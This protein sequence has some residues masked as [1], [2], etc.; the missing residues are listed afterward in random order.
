[1]VTIVTEAPGSPGARG[2]RA[3]PATRARIVAAG[4]AGTAAAT[5]VAAMALPNHGS[6]AAAPTGRAI[7]AEQ[8]GADDRS[9]VVPAPASDAA[10]PSPS[11][12]AA[13]D[14][15]TGGS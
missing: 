2:R 1:M 4:L 6:V 14:T 5:M 11:P 7:L 12:A 9:M 3:R 8:G 10:L 15:S 13:P